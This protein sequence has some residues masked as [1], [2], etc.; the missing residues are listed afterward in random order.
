MLEVRE[1]LACFR[2]VKGQFGMAPNLGAA[3]GGW[4]A[5]QGPTPPRS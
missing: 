5:K 4:K 1:K 2:E 3:R